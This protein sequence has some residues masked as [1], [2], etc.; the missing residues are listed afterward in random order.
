MSIQ[1]KAALIMTL[2]GAMIVILLSV[3][4]SKHGK[5]TLINEALENIQDIPEEVAL[6]LESH[7]LE[8]TAITTTL[9]SA[10]I[11]REALQK[12]NSIFASL[13]DK[14]RVEEIYNLNQEWKRAPI[15]DSFVQ[16]HMTS[17][18][19]ESLKYQQLIFPGEYGEI[20]LTNRYGAM[21][22]T[23]GKLSTHVSCP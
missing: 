14:G 23:A 13:P 11:I 22:A 4:Y 16:K 10:P 17:P 18:V 6:H 20:F 21:I 8:K 3:G 19:A 15:D 1:Y 12:S 7:L 5:L 2:Y 9:S